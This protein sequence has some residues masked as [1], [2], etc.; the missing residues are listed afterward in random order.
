[1]TKETILILDKENRTRWLLQTLLDSEKYIVIA[2]DSIERALQNFSEFQVSGLV[3][4]YRIGCSSALNAVRNLKSRS[5]ETYVMMLTADELT[6][7]EYREVIA[8][9]VD[10]YFAKP[11][12]SWKILVHLGK[13]LRQRSLLLQMR[14]QE[15]ELERLKNKA[16]SREGKSLGSPIPNEA[17]DVAEAPT[18]AK[19]PTVVNQ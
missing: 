12:P 8:A 13:G 17:K 6:E 2:V 5:P 4:E 3:T 7:K 16:G 10:D 11:F 9:G 19:T 1:M 18:T 15:E 14:W